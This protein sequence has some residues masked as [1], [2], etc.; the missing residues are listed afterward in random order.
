MEYVRVEN[1]RN[2]RNISSCLRCWCLFS[3]WNIVAAMF[4]PLRL[5]VMELKRV[6]CYKSYLRYKKAVV[7]TCSLRIR[8]LEKCSK[9]DIIPKFLKFRIPNNGCFDDKSVHDFQKRLLRKEIISAKHDYH[10]SA[11][12]ALEVRFARPLYVVWW[13][14]FCWPPLD[15]YILKGQ[16]T[17]AKSIQ[18][19]KTMRARLA[20]CLYWLG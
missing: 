15:I 1:A 14:S 2:V 5:L 10:S 7:D 4:L 9:A 16:Y 12:L 18:I 6:D 3:F 19:G 20:G 11:W 13:W 8:F 17:S